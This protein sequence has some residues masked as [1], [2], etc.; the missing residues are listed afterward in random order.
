MKVNQEFD[1]LEV[2][3]R[4]YD[5]RIQRFAEYFSYRL[6]GDVGPDDLVADALEYVVNN[7]Q[8]ETGPE[9]LTLIQVRI[10]RS[11][12][13]HVRRFYRR[14]QL[15]RTFETLQSFGPSDEQTRPES[16]LM[17][18]LSERRNSDSG[19]RGADSSDVKQH[20]SLLVDLWERVG[21]DDEDGSAFVAAVVDGATKETVNER[22]GWSNPKY[23]A[24]RKRVRYK[25]QKVVRNHPKL[26][27]LWKEKLHDD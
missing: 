11:A 5:G 18:A 25:T 20:D 26:L 21:Q 9:L 10:K 7:W 27:E 16:G 14:G 23:E 3:L 8:G 6:P 4:K 22:L 12:L 13:D 2:E 17:V 15:L 24:V 19:L 1:R